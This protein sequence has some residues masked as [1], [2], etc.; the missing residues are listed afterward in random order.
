MLDT[1]LAHLVDVASVFISMPLNVGEKFFY[2]YVLTFVAL[3]F[4]SFRLYRNQRSAS[5]FLKFL[6]PKQIYLHKSARVDYGIFLINLFISPLLLLGA[7]L[8]AWLSI[9]IGGALLG[10]NDGRAVLVGD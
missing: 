10:L 7:G 5:G 8:Q 6:F 1:L 4:V 9:E 3:A 2:V